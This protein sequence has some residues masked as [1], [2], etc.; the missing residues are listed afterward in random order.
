M[1]YAVSYFQYSSGTSAISVNTQAEWLAIYCDM[2]R[3]ARYSVIGNFPV[4]HTTSMQGF[5]VCSTF[6]SHYLEHV[7]ENY[8]MTLVSL[9]LS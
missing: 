4:S 9:S 6:G 7:V 5:F 3:I 2:Y 1:Y 8:N